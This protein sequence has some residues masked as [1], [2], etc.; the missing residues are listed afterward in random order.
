[1]PKFGAFPFERSQQVAF[2]DSEFM[3]AD[4]GFLVFEGRNAK[5]EATEVLLSHERNARSPGDTCQIVARARLVD[6][7]GKEVWSNK[8]IFDAN[9]IKIIKSDGWWHARHEPIDQRGRPSSTAREKNQ[10]TILHDIG[11]QG[12][13]RIDSLQAAQDQSMSVFF[14]D[15]LGLN[16]LIFT[17]GLESEPG[18]N[19]IS[20]LDL[21]DVV[22]RAKQ[23]DVLKRSPAREARAGRVGLLPRGRH[24]Q[25]RVKEPCFLVSGGR[26]SF[27]TFLHEKSF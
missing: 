8:L 22:D 24:H 6:D 13:G 5:F 3:D 19:L 4:D 9:D 2:S 27:T 23:S 18:A 26:C 12:F 15:V 1:M 14:V 20:R 21:G 10:V 16:D 25:V 7:P 17:I 11:G